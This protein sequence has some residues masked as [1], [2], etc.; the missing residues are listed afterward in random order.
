MGEP[1]C[2]TCNDTHRMCL[3]GEYED[4]GQM[5]GDA[6]AEMRAA[7]AVAE[8]EHEASSEQVGWTRAKVIGMRQL[9]AISERTVLPAL[10][11]LRALVEAD[12]STDAQALGKAWA[13]ARKAVGR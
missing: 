3:P 2:K 12:R 7:L 13:N 4:Q 1:I 9:L 10:D 6:L 5:V 8:A 11:A